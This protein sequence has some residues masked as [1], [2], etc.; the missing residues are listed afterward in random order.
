MLKPMRRPIITL[1]TDFG[2]KDG[3]IGA[4]KGVIK[5]INPDA[6]LVDITHEIEPFDVMGT[7]FSLRNYYSYYPKGTVHLVV[8]DPGVGSDR[9]PLLIKSED[10]FFVGPDNGVFTFV[11]DREKLTE[12]IQISNKKYFLSDLSTTFHTRDIFAPAAAY[13]SLGVDINEFGSPA[14]QCSKLLLPQPKETKKK[15]TGEIIHIDRFGNLITNIEVDLL[16][17][18]RV[19][20]IRTGKRL[21]KQISRSYF[22]IPI[23]KVGAL[24]GSSGF[25]EIAVNQ[26]SAQSALKAKMGT[27]VEINLR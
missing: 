22:E 9:Q 16:H 5:S 2:T 26:G 27:S 21:I 8:V 23:G 3:Y 11:Y 19:A 20:S 7:A 25:L 12:I 1:T 4:V 17:K 13:L 24:I 14:K 10:Y 6:Q 15:I 18:R